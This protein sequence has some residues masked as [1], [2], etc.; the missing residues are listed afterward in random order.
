MAKKP[1]IGRAVKVAGFIASNPVPFLIVLLVVAV[2]IIYVAQQIDAELTSVMALYDS[3]NSQR[4]DSKGEFDKRL[5]YV[6]VESD[7]TVTV[8]VGYK[9]EVEKEQAEQAAGEAG[10]PT[11]IG[12]EPGTWTGDGLQANALDFYDQ[13]RFGRKGVATGINI[14]GV[15]LYNGIPWDDDGNWY[16]LDTGAVSDYLEQNLG[17]SLTTSSSVHTDNY[18]TSSPISHNN[19]SCMGIAWQPIYCFCDISEAGGFSPG[20]S[21]SL[22]NQYYGVAILEKDG[23]EY[24]IPICSGGDNKGH[25]WPGGFVQTYVG[26]G[27]TLNTDTNTITISSGGATDQANCLWGDQ[28]IHGLSL[29]MDAFVGGWKTEMGYQHARNIGSSGHPML[30]LETHRNFKEALAGYEVKGFIIHKN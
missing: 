2:I 21:G 16:K 6:T 22:C 8:T 15:Q 18:N 26:N 25:T 4:Q 27:T 17:K 29:T 19:V 1:K 23:T 11:V 20:Y 28:R 5:Y 14:N 24:Y 13:V 10:D 9:S 12:G 7:G 3:V 30:S